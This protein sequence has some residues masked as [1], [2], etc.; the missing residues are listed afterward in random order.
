MER[1]GALVLGR[2][3]V[4]RRDAITACGRVEASGSASNVIGV[5][6]DC[7]VCTW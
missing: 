5:M 1:L 3:L 7:F 4:R 2:H 6:Y